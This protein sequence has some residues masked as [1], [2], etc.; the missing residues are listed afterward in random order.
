MWVSP[1]PSD[2]PGWKRTEEGGAEGKEQKKWFTQ[3]DGRKSGMQRQAERS[4]GASPDSQVKGWLWTLLRKGLG[5]QVIIVSS[6][7]GGCK[8]SKVREE[9]LVARTRTV[10]KQAACCREWCCHLQKW[11]PSFPLWA[12]FITAWALSHFPFSWFACFYDSVFIPAAHYLYI[13]VIG[14]LEQMFQSFSTHNEF[15]NTLSFPKSE[16]T[17]L[18]VANRSPHTL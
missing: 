5:S 6:C 1:G 12:V 2:G 8:E 11:G 15:E 3:R 16:D 18:A 13:K 4:E 14:T 17:V 9:D 7:K 10:T